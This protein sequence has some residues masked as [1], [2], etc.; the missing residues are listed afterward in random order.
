MKEMRGR[1]EERVRRWEWWEGE[2]ERRRGDGEE[3][4]GSGGRKGGS[5]RR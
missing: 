3:M 5:E 2:D 1:R 4:E